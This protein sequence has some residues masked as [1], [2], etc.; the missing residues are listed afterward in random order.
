MSGGGGFCFAPGGAAL[1]EMDLVMGQFADANLPAMSEAELDEFERL[2]D[3]P[4]PE[5]ARL[6]HRRRADAARVRHAAFRAP[7]QRAARGAR[8]EPTRAPMNLLAPAAR[9]LAEG[10]AV[11]LC[12][13]PEGYDAFVVAESHAARSRRRAKRAR[14]RSS[15]SPATASGRRPSSTRSPSPRRRSRRSICPRGTASP[16]TA[17]RRT[18]RFPPSA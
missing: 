17:C 6:D 1:R 13:A 11:T 7:R 3:V 5:V 14:S 18:P 10:G 4:D 8:R 9:R 2:L 12:R 15:S 16:T